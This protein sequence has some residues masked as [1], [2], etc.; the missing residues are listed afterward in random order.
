MMLTP[1]FLL[2][3]SNCDVDRKCYNTDK[4]G[5]CVYILKVLSLQIIAIFK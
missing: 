2:K 5:V 1:K 4:A 3:A